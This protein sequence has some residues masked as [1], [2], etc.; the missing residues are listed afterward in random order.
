LARILEMAVAG[1]AVGPTTGNGLRGG[2]LFVAA[3]SGLWEAEAVPSVASRGR[4]LL[5]LIWDDE[6]EGIISTSL[7]SLSIHF[8]G[9]LLA[10]CCTK[11]TTTRLLTTS[12]HRHEQVTVIS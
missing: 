8:N 1:A 7:Q 4:L 6:E 10:V 9:L 3:S 2:C 12:N 5:K 11:G